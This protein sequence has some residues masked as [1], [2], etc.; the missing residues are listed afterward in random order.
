MK[1]ITLEM[2]TKDKSRPKRHLVIFKKYYPKGIKVDIA[3]FSELAALEI[4]MTWWAHSLLGVHGIVAMQVALAES[5][6]DSPSKRIK[7][8]LTLAK[9]KLRNNDIHNQ[10]MCD[11]CN[12]LNKAT[13]EAYVELFSTNRTTSCVEE[14]KHLALFVDLLQ[15]KE[16]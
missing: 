4:H 14:E 11:V 10:E 6:L 12:A 5:V 9:Q 1:R 13:Y 8:L 16:I 15:Q 3:D 2:L 7:H